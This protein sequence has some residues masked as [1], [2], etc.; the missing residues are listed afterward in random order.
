MAVAAVELSPTSN[1]GV[2]AGKNSLFQGGKSASGTFS[3]RSTGGN[4]VDDGG[5][6]D[7]NG[8]GDTTLNQILA[9][10]G[11]DN[12]VSRDGGGVGMEKSPATSA[13]GGNG[14][15]D[16]GR[17]DILALRYVG[18]GSG[19]AAYSSVSNG[20]VSSVEGTGSKAGEA[21]VVESLEASFSSS[22][23]ASSQM[24]HHHHH[25]PLCQ[26]DSP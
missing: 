5:G 2:G 14:M 24:N 18:G 12:G 26:L 6:S 20:S 17:T 8:S 11:N 13:S 7:G 21:T 3:L 25:H 4:N 19:V 15:G 16:W 9:A 22:S 10:F 1:L 23:S